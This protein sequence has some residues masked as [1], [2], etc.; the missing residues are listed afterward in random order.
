MFSHV[1]HKNEPKSIRFDRLRIP[2]HFGTSAEVKLNLVTIQLRRGFNHPVEREESTRRSDVAGMQYPNFGS[3]TVILQFSGNIGSFEDLIKFAPEILVV[4][5]VEPCKCRIHL[6]RLFSRRGA[7]LLILSGLNI[8]CVLGDVVPL[9]VL[10]VVAS[11]GEKKLFS[12][13]QN[14]TSKIRRDEASRSK[15]DVKSV[16]V[17]DGPQSS[18]NRLK[19]AQ[20]S[21]RVLQIKQVADWSRTRGF[22]KRA[23]VMVVQW[24]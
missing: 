13:E 4:E 8:A 22:E 23:V 2:I 6:G 18:Q 12:E 3:R 10:N 5:A 17:L 24:W 11:P 20:D 14:P 9:R 7:W 1:D 16:V 15:Q 19:V 21:S